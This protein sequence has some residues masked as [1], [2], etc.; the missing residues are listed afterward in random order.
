[1]LCDQDWSDYVNGAYV[2]HACSIYTCLV[3]ICVTFSPRDW[4]E[5]RLYL[6]TCTY[7]WAEAKKV[8]AN[9]FWS[10]QAIDWFPGADHF[11]L[12]E[13]WCKRIINKMGSQWRKR[14][15]TMEQ[16]PIFK[17]SDKQTSHHS[18]FPQMRK[19][20]ARV[21]NKQRNALKQGWDIVLD[22][23]NKIC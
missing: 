19:N 17:G 20:D 16:V 3:I 21:L 11:I 15:M 2:T 18:I 4:V 13:S 7:K 1:M 8:N 10:K 5:K 14:Y 9:V 12:L 23:D 22:E 6:D